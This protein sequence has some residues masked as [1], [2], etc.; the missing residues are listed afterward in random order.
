MSASRALSIPKGVVAKYVKAA[1]ACGVNWAELAA[2]NEARLRALL[3]G[4]PRP[5]GTAEGYRMPDLAG[6]HQGLKRKNV[7]LALLWEEYVQA[8]AGPSEEA[9][10]A[11]RSVQRR[12]SQDKNHCENICHSVNYANKIASQP[13]EAR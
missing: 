2:A 11:R 9:Q 1:E 4:T 13:F 7:N 6:V 8:T 3:G 10:K 5:R 12:Y